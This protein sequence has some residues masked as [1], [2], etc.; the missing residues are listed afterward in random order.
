[1]SSVNR[2]IVPLSPPASSEAVRKAMQGNR[3]EGTRPELAL[4][5]AVHRRG[6]RYR[7][8][9]KPLRSLRCKADLIFPAA[10]VAVF[11]DGCFW[12]GCPDHGRVPSDAGGYWAAKLSRNV[13]RDRRNNE[14]LAKADWKVL[15]FWEHDDTD[16]AAAEIER[17]VKARQPQL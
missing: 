12:H 9:V 2:R 15:R 6:L 11:I 5:S 7:L 4:R 13:E 16:A 8:H 10:Q 1:M 3:S 17:V 14:A